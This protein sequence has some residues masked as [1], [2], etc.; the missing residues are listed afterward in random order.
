M[1]PGNS[2][3][4]DPGR[5]G[6]GRAQLEAGGRTKRNSIRLVRVDSPWGENLS[7]TCRGRLASKTSQS[8]IHANEEDPVD[9]Q[10]ETP[11][12]LNPDRIRTKFHE[13]ADNNSS[14]L[15]YT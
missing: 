8:P 3:P 14:G 1:D 12:E 2:A 5:G 11:S 7:L 9:R 15:G 13:A 10:G 6:Q 4:C